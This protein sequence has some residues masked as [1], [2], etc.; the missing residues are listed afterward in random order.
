MALETGPLW[1]NKFNKGEFM[2]E[3]SAPAPAPAPAPGPAPGGDAA[4]A[5]GGLGAAGGW[6]GVIAQ[7]VGYG[8]K[9]DAARATEQAAQTR[10]ASAEADRASTDMMR[11]WG[12]GG[13]GGGTATA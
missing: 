13:G 12:F 3:V 10:V 5:A 6:A 7:V 4:A 2:A 8:L 9:A 11:T 1:D